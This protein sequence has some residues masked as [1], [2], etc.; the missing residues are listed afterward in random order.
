MCR[1]FSMIDPRTLR[2]ITNPV[3]CHIIPECFGMSNVTVRLDGGIDHEIGA[4]CDSQLQRYMEVFFG[5]SLRGRFA[6]RGG[7]NSLRGVFVAS[8]NAVV[9]PKPPNCRTEDFASRALGMRHGAAEFEE[10]RGDTV[11][12]ARAFM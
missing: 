3:D 1:A 12:Q 11:D 4:K 6:F 10:W 7:S 5:D 8:Q 2:E 9:I